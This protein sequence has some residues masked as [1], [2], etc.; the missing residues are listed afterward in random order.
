MSTNFDK[1][2]SL[3]HFIPVEK[4]S[5][6]TKRHRDNKEKILHDDFKSKNILPICETFNKDLFVR[7]CSQ[8]GC[9]GIRIYYGMDSDLKIHAVV[10]AVDDTGADILP[11]VSPGGSIHPDG[12]GGGG[13]GTGEE[14]QMCPPT[15][16]AGSPLNGF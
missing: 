1:L 14:G 4:A 3:N 10:V 7:L 12:G 16:P 8:P 2:S 5:Q 6:M 15:C 13:T 11:S 9:A